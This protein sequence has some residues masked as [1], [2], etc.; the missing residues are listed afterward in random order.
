[1][2]IGERDVDL[3]EGRVSGKLRADVLNAAHGIC[4]MCGKSIQRDGI[5]LVVDHKRPLAWGGTNERS[6][7]WAICEQC[8]G[9]KQAFFESQD[10]N[11]MRRVVGYPTSHERI[12]ALLKIFGGDGVPSRLVELV[13]D[14]VDWR[15][16]LRE[17][18]YL[19][20][21][22]VALRRTSAARRVEILWKMQRE[23]EWGADM[24]TKIRKI[25]A[26]RRQKSASPH[27]QGIDGGRST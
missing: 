25:E 8:N 12:A 5:R 22:I 15:K 9:G 16:R 26:A 6:N 13:A 20:W 27:R 2:Y 18:R 10:R 7:L 17:L 1:M 11:V 21:K 23:G 24:T 4:Q 14:E 3:S 19:G